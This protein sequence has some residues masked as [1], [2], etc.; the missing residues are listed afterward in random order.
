MNDLLE[1]APFE[2]AKEYLQSICEMIKS[3]SMVYLNAPCDLEGVLAISHL[4]AA[5]IDSDIRYSRR[6][7]KSK[8]HTPHGEKQE[9]DVKKDGLTISIQP[10]E[11]TWKCSDLKIKDYVMIL[12]LSVSVRM[13]SKKS[14][15]MGALDVVSQCAAIAAKIA[16]NGARVRRLRPFAISGQWLRDSLDNTFDPIHSS[17]RD[18]LRD[19]GSVSVVP[20]P[21]VSVPAQDMIPNLSQTMLKRLRKRWDKMD[22]DSRSQAISELALP[23]LIDNVISTPRL[24]ELFWHR[25]MIRGEEQDIYSQIHLTKND[26]PTEEGQTKAHSST[27]LRGLISQGKLGN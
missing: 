27:I 14:E 15:R 23:S 17:I 10:F 13:G 9:V 18:I 19:E 8:Q 4:E 20:L 16:P 21:E 12:P 26:W 7:V 5:C 3:T 2:D 6:L 1:S 11:E 22:F 25:L 24:E